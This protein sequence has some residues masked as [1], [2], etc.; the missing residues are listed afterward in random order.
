M[1][2]ILAL[3]GRL[4]N[5]IE[6]RIHTHQHRLAESNIAA[7]E[8]K[9]SLTEGEEQMLRNLRSYSATRHW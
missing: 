7:L 1:N 6:S 5:G 8:A 4:L 2:N 3:P 9:E